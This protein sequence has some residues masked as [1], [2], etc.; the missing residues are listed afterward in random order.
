MPA[1]IGLSRKSASRR[2]QSSSRGRASRS[3]RLGSRR[4]SGSLSIGGA[5]R[6]KYGSTRAI[7]LSRNPRSNMYF[8]E[9]IVNT[10][11]NTYDAYFPAGTMT[12][13][14][15][16]YFDLIVNAMSPF[17]GVSYPLTLVPGATYA[18]HAN[19]VQGCILAQT[20]IGYTELAGIYTNYR[21]IKYILEITV[22]PT[23]ASDTTRVVVMPLGQEEI[24]GAGAASVNLK[25]FESQP[26]ALAKTFASGVTPP[27]GN[28]IQL[29]GYPNRDLGRTMSEYMSLAP[30]AS[31]SGPAPGTA[32]V[33]GVFLQQL[34]G[35]NNSGVVTM[36][37]KL[38]QEVEWY[39]LIPA[40][41]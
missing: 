33:V 35:A 5:R 2:L 41:T 16:N 37:I 39:E 17:T 9:R 7:V 38:M 12:A 3:R 23:N 36:Q 27:G 14:A 29:I 8:P 32:D 4:S 13:A 6:P 18:A 31:G 21:V 26:Y 25:V 22:V 30:T 1:K 15:G 24:P 20:P 19:L 34:N 11:T 28:S 10:M 40:L